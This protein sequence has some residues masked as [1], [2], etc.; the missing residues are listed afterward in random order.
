MNKKNKKNK[1]IGISGIT[2]QGMRKEESIKVPSFVGPSGHLNSTISNL[3][4]DSIELSIASKED[5]D[6]SLDRSLVDNT[7]Q[8]NPSFNYTVHYVGVNEEN[9]DGGIK[10][11]KTTSRRTRRKSNDNINDNDNNNSSNNAKVVTLLGPDLAIPS[12]EHDKNKGLNANSSIYST[13]VDDDLIPDDNRLG[14]SINL[15]LDLHP[16]KTRRQMKFSKSL[17][18][19]AFRT[20]N[21]L[22]NTKSLPFLKSDDMTND[23]SSVGTS[24][25]GPA[26][27]KFSFGDDFEYL[28]DNRLPEL[29]LDVQSKLNDNNK[30][31]NQVA[32][33]EA[34]KLEIKQDNKMNDKEGNPNLKLPHEMSMSLEEASQLTEATGAQI[35]ND[36]KADIDG[37]LIPPSRQLLSPI[38]SSQ[39]NDSSV[40]KNAIS[41]AFQ[42]Q[43]NSEGE[44]GLNRDASEHVVHGRL[45]GW[46]LTSMKRRKYLLK[47]IRRKYVEY[48][49]PQEDN[50]FDQVTKLKEEEEIA[51]TTAKVQKRMADAYQKSVMRSLEGRA[52]TP[53]GRMK[54]LK[55]AE[56]K[57]QTPL[58]VDR[59]NLLKSLGNT[60]PDIPDSLVNSSLFAQKEMSKQSLT[61]TSLVDALNINNMN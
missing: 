44:F 51:K 34:L 14:H 15:E 53:R 50:V 5:D 31:D 57:N 43:E 33:V 6:F 26:D 9:D 46:K 13:P 61:M 59:M 4:E 3:A 17:K 24:I 40:M 16:A 11:V 47:L 37:R 25:V 49:K 55:D 7:K 10:Q 23:D 39:I 58:I 41:I 48:E 2:P 38:T 18:G 29:S 27:W 60:I 8:M 1:S 35:H 20:T 52:S 36:I 56:A 32:E 21:T 22:N 45:M 19:S 30:I 28:N 54:V 42:R 12:V